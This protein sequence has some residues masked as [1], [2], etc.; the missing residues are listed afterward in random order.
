MYSMLITSEADCSGQRLDQLSST[1][2]KKLLFQ[3][4]FSDTGMIGHDPFQRQNSVVCGKKKLSGPTEPKSN[5]P[6]IS[7]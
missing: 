2:Y 1:N 3:V 6:F 4:G 7:Y 5:S